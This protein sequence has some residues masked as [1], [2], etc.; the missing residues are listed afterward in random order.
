M[1][2]ARALR[3]LGLVLVFAGTIGTV[4]A[5]TG[6]MVGTDGTAAFPASVVIGIVVIIANRPQR[7]R[8]PR[9]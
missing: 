9:R 8:R 6:L 4:A 1:S 2:E 7:R 5:L 3:I